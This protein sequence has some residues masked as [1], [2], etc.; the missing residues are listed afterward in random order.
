[1]KR[2]DTLLLSVTGLLL[3][4]GLI[5]LV[6][7]SS[8]QGVKKFNDSLYYVKH[9]VLYGLLPALIIFGVLLW[10]PFRYYQQHAFALL[11]IGL[12][13]L[14]LVFTH[15]G[16]SAG[17]A[18]RWLQIG[19]ASFQPVEFFKVFFVIYLAFWFHHFRR[20]T[21]NQFILFLLIVGGSI[22]LILI[23]PNTS[24]AV[25]IS[26]TAF[27]MYVASGARLSHVFIV[28]PVILAIFALLIFS[29]PYRLERFLTF[30]HPNADPLGSGYHVNQSL[31]AL[32]SG[33]LTGVG[34]GKS[35]TKIN[36]LPEPMTD[37]IFAIIGE[38]IG[39]IGSL[40]VLTLITM[41]I[42]RM[43]LLSLKT[44]SAFGRLTIV[45]FASILGS[46][47]LLNISAVS[48]LIPFTGVPLPF[49]SYGGS[50]LIANLAMI[51]ITLHI[52]RN[53]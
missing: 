5:F 41:L 28:A 35:T 6:S 42:I 9:Q 23:Q 52:A 4:I 43:F 12:V 11:I 21:K 15:L 40:G 26:A 17:G 7:S 16:L 34:F 22:F 32:G 2:F 13:G 50:A 1:M 37:S 39:L 25:L 33:G 27:I 20:P 10:L 14:G 19:A 38:E 45:G 31:T 48:G 8:Y 47:S 46:Q 44:R 51:G 18:T 53:N 3:L 30:L 29:T 24:A 49:I 36:F